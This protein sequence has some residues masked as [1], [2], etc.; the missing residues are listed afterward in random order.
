MDVSRWSLITK[1]KLD[2][3][4]IE[5]I[6]AAFLFFRVAFKNKIKSAVLNLELEEEKK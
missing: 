5:I 2:A 4:Q 3:H 6:V 1:K